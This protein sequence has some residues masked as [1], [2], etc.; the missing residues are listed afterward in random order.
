MCNW[1]TYC[2][3]PSSDLNADCCNNTAALS[4]SVSALGLP[5]RAA[6]ITE[7]MTSSVVVSSGSTIVLTTS[8]EMRTANA[9]SNPTCASNVEAKRCQGTSK[10][11]AVGAG[12]G[13]S[14]GTVLLATLMTLVVLMRRQKDLRSGLARARE[15]S[16]AQESAMRELER[17]VPKSQQGYMLAHDVSELG[18]PAHSVNELDGSGR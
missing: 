3:R 11:M 4:S 12:V 18:V 2:C 15:K 5:T 16:R 17:S 13:I 8:A 6:A 7:T 1:N 10:I 9:A 14:L